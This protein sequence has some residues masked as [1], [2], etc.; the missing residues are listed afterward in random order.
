VVGATVSG[1]V[2]LLAKDFLRLVIIATLLASPLAWWAMK[3]WL[4]G[5]AYSISIEWWMF[6]LTA[7]LAVSVAV[8]TISFQSIKAALMNPV[9][10]LKSE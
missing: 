2:I 10:S 4:E 6:V 7:V 5:F 9:K 8:L 3:K 1:V